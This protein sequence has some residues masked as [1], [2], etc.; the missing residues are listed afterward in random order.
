MAVI[1]FIP[2]LWNAD[3]LGILEKA[4]VYAGPGVVNR[5]YEGEITGGGDTVNITSVGTP[6]VSAYVPGTTTVTP[7][8]IT[9]ANRKLLIDQMNY[10]AVKI[11]DVDRRQSKDGGRLLRQ[12]AQQAAYSIRDTVDQYVAGLFSGAQAANQISTTSITTAALAVTGLVNLGVK[13]DTANVPQE[14]R[15]VVIPPW[16]YGLLL[17][18][19]LFVRVDASGTDSGLRNGVVG[20]AFGFR[21]YKSNN[22]VN[23]TG[24]D[25][26][27][28]AGYTGAIT[29]AEQIV[30][31]E[32]YR[33]E[34][35]FSDA[36][37]GLHVCGAKLV[38]PEGIATLIA[39]IT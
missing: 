33:P 31:T 39:S 8:S 22:V 24:D 5:D 28:T 19:D 9:D 25:Y 12:A 15:F 2:E 7:E 35:S 29:Y 1:N 32:A 34:S 37:K 38:R 27:I 30:E 11:D 16:Y 36:I 18:S 13:L 21:V 26:R 4:T 6:T 23:T 3:V 20:D 14:G 17:Q 10:Y